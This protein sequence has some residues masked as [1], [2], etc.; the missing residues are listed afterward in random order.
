MHKRILLFTGILFG[1]FQSCLK[2]DF[3]TVPSAGK[4]R[5][6]K[7]T[8]FLDTIFTGISSSTYRLKV[9]NETNQNISIPEVRL[10]RGDESFFRLNVDGVPG[11]SV[12]DVN[13]LAH[14]SIFI[15]IEATVDYSKV[16]N[17]VY[18]DSIVFDAGSKMQDVKLVTLVQ[19]AHFLYPKRDSEGVKEKIVL[20][21][22]D[23]GNAITVEGFYLDKNTVWNADKPYVIY[24]FAG[25]PPGG[26]L[27]VEK[28][29]RIHFHKNS[30]LLVEKGGTIRVNGELDKEVIFE[31][32]R[33]EPGFGEIPGQWSTIWLRS[34]S[35]DN[36][37]NYAIIKNN[38]LGILV[39]SIAEPGVA[40]LEIENTQIYNTS[41]F[42][43]MGRFT[44]INGANLVIGNNGKASLAC[45]IGGSYDFKHI[46]LANFWSA[47]ARDFPALYVSNFTEYTDEN[48]S[49]YRIKGDL[50]KANFTSCIIYGNKLNEFLLAKDDEAQFEYFFKNNLI[51]FDTN[52]DLAKDPL[53]DFTDQSLYKNNILNG[54]PDF[55]DVNL[56]EYIIGADSDAVGNA[57][58]GA[59]QQFPFDLLGVNR[60]PNPDIGAYQHIVFEEE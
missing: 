54:N 60:L 46:T 34:G 55:K 17:P 36:I 11:N 4:L 29:S 44:H 35:K 5:F 51:R 15:F 45:T 3:E 1:V 26:V 38:T 37:I 50:T 21:Y 53:Y 9:Y 32:D 40:T 12:K 13:I 27:T 18:T 31:G 59:A 22:D 23:Q 2:N 7:D 24:G 57:D 8:V 14:D 28:G 39:D 33:L 30:G 47:A 19:D 25:V 41:S 52:S 42:G 48:G 49:R 20:G 43:L 58:Q 16:I 6:S 10:G 56:N